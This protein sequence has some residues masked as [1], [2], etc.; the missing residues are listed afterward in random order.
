MLLVRLQLGRRQSDD[1]L[2]G[3]M[4][5]EVVVVVGADERG[6]LG[7][8]IEPVQLVLVPEEC[9]PLVVTVAPA[10]CPQGDQ[11]AVGET[12][13]DRDDVSRSHDRKPIEP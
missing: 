5:D 9:L 8:C 6:Q 11:I 7:G 12:E 4:V 13:L 3:R 1:D 2:P 10:W